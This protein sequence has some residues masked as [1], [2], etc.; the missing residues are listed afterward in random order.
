[1]RLLDADAPS[2]MWA[3]TANATSQAPTLGDIRSGRVGREGSLMGEEIHGRLERRRSSLGG[4]QGLERTGTNSSIGAATPGTESKR[5]RTRTN[6]SLSIGTPRFGTK[7]QGSS[8]FGVGKKAS[9]EDIGGTAEP[10]PS[11]KEREEGADPH[12]LVEEMREETTVE[13]METKKAPLTEEE[14]AQVCT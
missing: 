12:G 13:K 9:G 5:S 11:V 1:M 8:G 14:I 3:A 10:F 7:R 6:S 2:G 4:S